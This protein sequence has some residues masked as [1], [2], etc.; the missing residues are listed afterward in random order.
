MHKQTYKFIPPTLLSLSMMLLSA[1]GGG[2]GSA[3]SV[4]WRP[5]QQVSESGLSTSATAPALAIND[6]AE[7]HVS[8]HRVDNENGSSVLSRRFRN[9]W[10]SIEDVLYQSSEQPAPSR[11]AVDEAGN[12]VMI[13]RQ[14]DGI[15]HNLWAASYLLEHGWGQPTLLEEGSGSVGQAS[16]AMNGAG[17]AVVVWQ[18]YDGSRFN[19]WAANYSVATDNWTQAYTLEAQ[20]TNATAPQ[21]QMRADGTAMAVWLQR[22][23]GDGTPYQVW[24]NHMNAPANWTGAQLLDAE[25]FAHHP[26]LA[27][28]EVGTGIVV[29]LRFADGV[30]EPWAKRCNLS[31]LICSPA[32]QLSAAPDSAHAPNIA[33]DAAGRAMVVWSAEPAAGGHAV[34]AVRHENVGLPWQI[35]WSAPQALHSD[36]SPSNYDTMNADLAMDQAGNAWVVW[37]GRDA[38]ARGVILVNGFNVAT[39]T[40]SGERRLSEADTNATVPRIAASPQGQ[41]AAAWSQRRT[42]T[43][44]YDSFVSRYVPAP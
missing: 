12:A 30:F 21:V 41:A 35:S 24:R 42:A 33:M 31:N 23:G 11:I 43:T 27:L 2:S 14:H 4:G 29:W 36:G 17:E 32:A 1:C 5:P 44:I 38:N 3:A 20:D 8:W 15:R 7:L 37:E 28:S 40:W 26:Q 16:L 10:H 18:Q 25:G 6:A 22:E 9:H 34:F 39:G 19:I 13:W